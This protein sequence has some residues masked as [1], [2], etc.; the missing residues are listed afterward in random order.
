MR[1]R[2]ARHVFLAKVAVVVPLIAA[3]DLLFHDEVG[4]WLSGL[5]LAWTIMLIAVRP[6]LRRGPALIAG[7]AASVFALI[8]ADVP[9]LL[10][11][12]L[13][14]IAISIVA[15][16][17][18][19]DGFDD[20]WRWAARVL[21]HGTTGPLAP[22]FALLRLFRPRPHRGRRSASPK[23]SVC[24]TVFKWGDRRVSFRGSRRQISE[25]VGP[26]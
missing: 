7:G 26:D 3:A 15:L 20:A 23:P 8:A 25:I 18:R 24:A 11:W 4:S 5:M 2:S 14:W 19:A 17:P 9:G 13:S 6:A 1:R 21:T 10:D 12:V 22:F 16:L